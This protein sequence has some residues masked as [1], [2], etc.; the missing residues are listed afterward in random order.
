MT[1]LFLIVSSFRKIYSKWAKMCFW[2]IWIIWKTYSVESLWVNW[3]CKSYAAQCV[4]TDTTVLH[5]FGNDQR[6]ENACLKTIIDWSHKSSCVLI[7]FH[8][9]VLFL[10][11]FGSF[12][13]VHGVMVGCVKACILR[14]N[15][16]LIRVIHCVDFP[17]GAFVNVQLLEEHVR[18]IDSPFHPGKSVS[19]NFTLTLKYNLLILFTIAVL[20]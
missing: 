18:N 16:F 13:I 11:L 1:F 17:T 12:S 14:A 15:K 7:L 2:V 10:Q 19:F 6:R 3:T 20:L 9:I 5:V 8:A 4:S